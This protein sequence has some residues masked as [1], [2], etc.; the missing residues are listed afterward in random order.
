[1]ERTEELSHGGATGFKPPERLKFHRIPPPENIGTMLLDGKIDASLMYLTDVNL[2]DRSRI[3]L[4]NRPEVRTLFRDPAAE[5]A[6][7]YHKTGFY[8][9]NHCV[10][11]QRQVLER[12]PW[13][14][15]NIFKAFVAAKDVAHGPGREIAS[16][17]FDLDLLPRSERRVLDIDPYPYGVKVN[18]AM[19]EAL[20][21]FSHEQGL[22]PR[23][24]DLGEIFHPAT[25]DL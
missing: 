11:V 19:L 1:M 10:V 8:P 16:I 7:Y 18:R 2:V 3:D 4:R 5:G 9:A 20:V 17:Y 14:A 12:H 22:T 23:R 6:R 25:L 15:L 24:L 21:Q 13:A